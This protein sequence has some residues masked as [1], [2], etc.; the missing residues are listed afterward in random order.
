MRYEELMS[1]AYAAWEAGLKTFVYKGR[2]FKTKE[3]SANFG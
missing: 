1:K 2:T 3:F